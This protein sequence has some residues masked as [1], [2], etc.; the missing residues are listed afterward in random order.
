M[1]I[2]LAEHGLVFSTRNR[3]ERLRES[4]VERIDDLW[5]V[6]LTFDF[7]EV[8]SASYSFVDELIGELAERMAPNAP[9]V[10]NAP[11]TIVGTI[12]RSL[13]NRGLDS[14]RILSACLHYA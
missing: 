12:E 6:T 9:D 3:G 13:R 2:R 5:T 8:I 1:Q 14:E 4:L 11:P 10:V 7:E